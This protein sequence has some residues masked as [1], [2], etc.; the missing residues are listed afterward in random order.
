MKTRIGVLG[1]GGVGGYFGGLLAGKYNNSENVEVVFIARPDTEKAIKEQG[2]KLITPEKEEVVYPDLITSAINSI[3]TLDVLIV[4]VKSYDLITSVI[5]IAPSIDKNTIILPLLNGVDAKDKISKVYPDN[6]V[7]DGCVFVISKIVERGVIKRIAGK[8]VLYFG[9]TKENERLKALHH[10]FLE[11]GINAKYASNILEVVW[12]KYLF[13]ASLASL[14]SYL[15]ITTGQIFENEKHKELLIQL[16]EEFQAVANA[17]Q[18]LLSKTIIEETVQKIEALPYETTTSMQ[19]DF[20]QNR[21][22]EYKSLTKHIVDLGNELSI[23][24]PTFKLVL[25]EL[26]RKNNS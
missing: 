19:R 17:K 26:E 9:A 14:T 13:I 18:I 6:L 25:K 24:V 2:L 12:G 3:G 5:N 4:A 15:D 22:T 21:K 16:L 23:S 20:Q 10:I 11:A 1:L 8:G 7:L